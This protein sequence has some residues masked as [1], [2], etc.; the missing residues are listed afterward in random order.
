VLG[1]LARRLAPQGS[2]LLWLGGEDP[3]LPPTLRPGRSL[4]LS[5]SERRRIL[6][7]RPRGAS[8]RVES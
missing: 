6:E 1:A 5:G 8:E 7:L 4:A 3:E 2:V